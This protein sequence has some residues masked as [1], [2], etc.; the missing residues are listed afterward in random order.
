MNK[1]FDK[2]C[3]TEAVGLGD[4]FVYSGIIHHFAEKTN[5][6]FIQTRLNYFDTATTLFQDYDN[7]TVFSSRCEQEY[8]SFIEKIIYLN[9][10]VMINY[11]NLIQLYN[12]DQ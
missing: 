1:I 12:M 8:I 3:F 11:F 5:E 2:L 6:V 9:L 4:I 10:S 7:I